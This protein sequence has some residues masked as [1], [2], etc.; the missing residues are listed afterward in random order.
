MSKVTNLY[1]KYFSV[2]ITDYYNNNTFKNADHYIDWLLMLAKKARKNVKSEN[3]VFV[4]NIIHESYALENQKDQLQYIALF[5][6]FN[7]R[8]I[9]TVLLLSPWDK[10]INSKVFP[11]DHV[12]AFNWHAWFTHHLL[13]DKTKNPL[14]PSWNQDATKF[15]V[16]TGKPH[17]VNR[18][19][20]LWKLSQQN[21]LEKSIWSLLVHK[22]TWH[23]SR[24][25][26]P[27][28][29]DQ[30]FENFIQQ[31]NRKADDA[32][33]N[34]QKNSLHYLGIPYDVN[35]YK[36]S[37]FR[38]IPD[39]RFRTTD[40]PMVTDKVYF[41][42][43]NRLPFI[44]AGDTGSIKWLKDQGF[45][46]FE[47]YLPNHDYDDITDSETRLDAIISNCKYWSEGMKDKEQIQKDVEFNFNHLNSIANQT[48]QDIQVFMDRVGLQGLTAHDIMSSH[49][50]LT[51]KY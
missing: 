31:Y 38:V 21:L 22:G 17:E 50:W 7:K 27:E 33:I 10:N 19:R 48:A 47:Q 45:K 1:K 49:D 34:F 32:K 20:L 4:C 44:M 51:N 12:Q 39:T 6:R 28:L 35:L 13:I 9:K 2:D 11:C 37:L 25:L 30:Q 5:E 46:T 24:E 43:F 40:R 14:N 16:L 26:L 36:Q 8:G 3:F 41:T 42:I 29:S 15:L 23:K 18:I